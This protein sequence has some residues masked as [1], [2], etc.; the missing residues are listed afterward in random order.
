MEE[1][2]ASQAM[3][4]YPIGAFLPVPKYGSGPVDHEIGGGSFER[5]GLTPLERVLTESRPGGASPS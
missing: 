1:A 2:R 3:A 5:S 4:V